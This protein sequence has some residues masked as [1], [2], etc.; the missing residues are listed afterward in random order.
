MERKFQNPRIWSLFQL[1]LKDSS[2][3]CDANHDVH[4][5]ENLQEKSGPQL[6]LML[7]RQET[8]TMAHSCCVG[9][10]WQE[11]YYKL[12]FIVRDSNP[13][14]NPTKSRSMLSG[15][16]TLQLRWLQS[17]DDRQDRSIERWER[18]Q[19]DLP[20]SYYKKFPSIHSYSLWDE[21]RNKE[22]VTSSQI[23]QTGSTSAFPDYEAHS[24]LV[25]ETEA[26]TLCVR[27]SRIDQRHW[28]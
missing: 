25:N 1:T 15:R 5:N 9:M 24:A 6:S 26:K 18:I 11:N 28:I 21:K 22:W 27:L 3:W 23:S 7:E 17:T 20:P 8:N 2:W 16:Q 12:S 10:W 4:N 19:V 13:V 14:L